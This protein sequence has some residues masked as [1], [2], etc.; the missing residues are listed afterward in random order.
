[1]MKR[2]GGWAAMVVL[3]AACGDDGGNPTDEDTTTSADGADTDTGPVDPWAAP[4]ETG[5]FRILYNERGRL[6]ENADQ[7]ELWLMGADGKNQ[8]ALTDLAGLKDLDPPLSCNYGCVVSP[9]LEWIAVVTGPPGEKGFQMKLGRFNEDLEVAL[10]KGDELD[11][12][13][14]FHFAGDRM[15]YSKEKSCTGPSCTYEI[16]VVELEENVNITVPF[17]TFPP[18]A[19][20]RDS[21]Y[22]GHFDVSAD[23][24]NIVMLNTTIRSVSVYLWKDGSGLIELDYLCKYGGDKANCQGTGSEYTDTDPV[25]IDA[26]GRYIAFFTFAD[27]WQRIRLYDTQNPSVIKSSI[28]ASVPSGP[29]IEH[30]CDPGVIAD[31]QWQRVVG[32]PSFTPDGQEIVFLGEYACRENGLEPKKRQTNIYRVKLDT[33]VRELTLTEQDVFNV[34]KHPRGDVTANRHPSAF[35]LSPDGATA[36]FTGT[37]TF[38]QSGGLIADGS[39][40]QRND[41]EVYRIRLD[42]TNPVQLT[43]DLSFQSESPMVIPQ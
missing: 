32:D 22:K 27:R 5:A 37:P 18:D 24:K 14:D 39:A 1:M 40:R 16:S 11:D 17:L 34:T 8:L 31:W 19:E 30:A 29:W 3:V 21:T 10:L 13:I 28:V 26:S 9:D 23:G 2:S 41:R 43:N 33:V 25:A 7:N 36:V 6:P 38:D 35:A 15:F 12:I 20:L 42:G 4:V